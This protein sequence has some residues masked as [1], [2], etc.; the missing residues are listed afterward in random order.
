MS[1]EEKGEVSSQ[2]AGI[3]GGD[4]GRSRQEAGVSNFEK[5]TSISGK[6]RGRRL[7]EVRVRVGNEGGNRL[8]WHEERAGLKGGGGG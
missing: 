6:N 5:H 2:V 7:Q 4:E 1:W 3:E 8:D